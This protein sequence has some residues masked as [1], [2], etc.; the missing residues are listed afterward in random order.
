MAPFFTN[1]SIS[2]LQNHG[3][4][5]GKTYFL[6]STETS[7]GWMSDRVFSVTEGLELLLIGLK[8]EIPKSDP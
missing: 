4:S 8:F 6:E 3:G 7:F 2:V 5:I 1:H